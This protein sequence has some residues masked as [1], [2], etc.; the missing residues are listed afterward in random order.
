MRRLTLPT[1]SPSLD[2][3]GRF[4]DELPS[5]PGSGLHVASVLSSVPETAVRLGADDAPVPQP[6][7]NTYPWC[8]IRQDKRTLRDP[9][10]LP[11]YPMLLPPWCFA[12]SHSDVPVV[13]TMLFLTP[14]PGSCRPLYSECL[15]HILPS[16]FSVHTLPLWSECVPPK[17]IWKPRPQTDGTSR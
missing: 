11:L 16:C 17:F 1:P 3:E 6:C 9:A 8:K 12:C 5:C 10:L 4:S 13:T 7:S 15:H 14:A 2:T